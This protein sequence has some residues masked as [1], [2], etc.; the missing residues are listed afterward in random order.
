MITWSRHHQ[1]LKNPL[2]DPAHVPVYLPNQNPVHQLSNAYKTVAA[3]K[4]AVAAILHRTIAAVAVALE[5]LGNVSGNIYTYVHC[6]I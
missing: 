1:N 6:E 3:V 2:R 5:A 4:V